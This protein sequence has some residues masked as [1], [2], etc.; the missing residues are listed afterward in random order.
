MT[1]SGGGHI[2]LVKR[3]P[4]H[5]GAWLAW[6][7]DPVTLRFMAGQPQGIDRL[8]ARLGAVKSDL[9][10]RTGRLYRWMAVIK[11]VPIGTVSLSDPDWT[12]GHAEIGYLVAP[13]L[14]GRRVGS[15]MVSLAIEK[16]FAGGLFRLAAIIHHQNL[17]SHRLVERPASTRAGPIP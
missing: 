6:A 14:R 3:E 10:D 4:G 1:G 16:A 15:R 7:S 9:A 5:A 12:H 17:A 13:E 2:R 11:D 8:A